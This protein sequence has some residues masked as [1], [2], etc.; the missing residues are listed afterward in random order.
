LAENPRA[1]AEI[2][3]YLCDSLQALGVHNGI[4]RLSFVRLDPDGKQKPCVELLLP[5]FVVKQ[6][7]AA[8]QAVKP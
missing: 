8:L 7:A 6:V 5:N 3:A 2:P 1:A 4:T